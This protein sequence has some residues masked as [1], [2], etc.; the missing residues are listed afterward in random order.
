[1]K[2]KPKNLTVKQLFKKK[3]AASKTM[4]NIAYGAALR[5]V[6]RLKKE[7][8]E[9]LNS[10]PVTKEIEQG[11]SGMN[12]QLMGG[13][14]NLFA[15]LGFRQSAKPVEIIRQGFESFIKIEKIPKLKKSTEVSLEWEF[16]IN[17]PSMAEIYGVTP[18]PWTTMSWVKGIER[19][20]GNFTNTIFGRNPDSRSGFAVQG[21]K[22]RSTYVNFSPV[23]YVTPM[24]MKFKRQLR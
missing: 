19:G 14:G 17:Y 21:E 23:P 24:L 16:P 1:M 18:L 10:H 22:P 7:L 12:S 6:N 9:E 11:T 8:V 15:F 20:I 3:I 13:H 2:L 4:Q 5:K